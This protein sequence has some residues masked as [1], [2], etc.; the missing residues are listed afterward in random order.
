MV[1]DALGIST[2][3]SREMI[4][5]LQS[6]LMRLHL[7]CCVQFWDPDYKINLGILERVAV[8]GFREGPGWIL[9]TYR[10]ISREGATKR[11][12]L[13]SVMPNATIRRRRDKNTSMGRVQLKVRKHLLT[14][15]MSE[16]WIILFRIPGESLL[17]EISKSCIGLALLT[18]DTFEKWVRQVDL[19][20]CHRTSVIA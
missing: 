19:L 20:R 9:F 17:L 14:V 15:R 7:E 18:R 10:N 6:V 1:L 2:Q 12:R 16:Q 5:P 3:N 4:D 13:F 8:P 11:A